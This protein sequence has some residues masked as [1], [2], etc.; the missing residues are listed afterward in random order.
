MGW[1]PSWE[2]LGL[3]TV[4]DDSGRPPHCGP[5]CL[6]LKE[7]VVDL[8]QP[9][10]GRLS[11]LVWG[12]TNLVC[13]HRVCRRLGSPSAG[14]GR[15]VSEPLQRGAWQRDCRTD[16]GVLN[17]VSPRLPRGGARGRRLGAKK[18]P[19]GQKPW[20]HHYLGSSAGGL[21]EK[22]GEGNRAR[23]PC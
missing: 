23:F 16:D 14:S 2:A 4:R 11:G 6:F 18:L 5:R 9:R 19:S 21:A 15:P 12:I 3:K 17:F 22:L 13:S 1:T 7:A 8:A 20:E 10:L